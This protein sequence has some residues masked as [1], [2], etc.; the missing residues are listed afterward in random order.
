MLQNATPLRKSAPWPTNISDEHVSCTALATR[1]ASLSNS[2][3]RFW[4]CYKTL[5]FCSLLARCRIPCACHAKP[6]LNFRKWSEH[7]VLLAFWLGNVLRVAPQRHAL[8]SKCQLP[9][10]VRH[11]GVLYILTWKCASRHNGVHFF[12]ISTSKT[13]LRPLDFYTFDFERC[14]A[15]QRRAFFH[16]LNFQTCFENGVFCN[17]VQFFISH[18]AR[19]LRTRRFSEPTCRP[20]GATNHLKNTVFCNFSAFSCTCIFFPLTL[21]ILWSSFFFFL[22]LFSSL[23]LPTS[24]FPSVHIAGS[25][26]SKLP[27]IIY[28]YI[29]IFIYIYMFWNTGEDIT[30]QGIW[31]DIW[32]DIYIYN[33]Y[34]ILSC[35]LLLQFTKCY[36]K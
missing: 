28:I 19:W 10:A 2:C 22:L 14:F 31:C 36:Y 15:P 23:A 6:H 7:A 13:G 24:A 11:W 34:M 21:S 35:R 26:T 16:P 12:I 20:S 3:H 29:R 18:L 5:T 30:W 32:C 9:K 27:L 8:F 1:Y 33:I 17:G 25:L 4:K